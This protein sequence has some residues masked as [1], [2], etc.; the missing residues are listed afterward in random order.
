[1]NEHIK[2]MDVLGTTPTLV[3]QEVKSAA[4]PEVKPEALKH[5]EKKEFP[6]Q[7]DDVEK[8]LRKLGLSL[9]EIVDKT[10]KNGNVIK[11]KKDNVARIYVHYRMEWLRVIR[12]KD[13]YRLQWKDEENQEGKYWGEG[14]TEKEYNSFLHTASVKKRINIFLKYNDTLVLRKN[15]HNKRIEIR[16][17]EEEYRSVQELAAK[18]GKRKVSELLRKRI[19]GTILHEALSAEEKQA[20]KALLQMATEL[21]QYGTALKNYLKTTGTAGAQRLDLLFQS[22]PGT[23]YS[24]AIFAASRSINKLIRYSDDN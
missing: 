23:D 13:G 18:I 11:T 24:K 1:M 3:K 16:V 15:K 2:I 21:K 20:M 4:K 9:F 6:P 14:I 7:I 5:K 12:N 8:E 19:R 22:Q 17:S 10:D